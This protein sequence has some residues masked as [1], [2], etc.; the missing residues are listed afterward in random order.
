[1]GLPRRTSGHREQGQACDRRPRAVGDQSVDLAWRQFASHRPDTYASCA[2]LR[3]A[4]LL[5]TAEKTMEVRIVT[6]ELVNEIA[7]KSIADGFSVWRAPIGRPGVAAALLA[8]FAG[9]GPAC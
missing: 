2:V 1:M 8:R 7:E 6:L 5:Y 9:A 3:H 4:S